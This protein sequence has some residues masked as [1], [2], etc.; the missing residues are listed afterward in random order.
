LISAKS[1]SEHDGWMDEHT[2]T[3]AGHY[4]VIFELMMKFYNTPQIDQ[5][6]IIQKGHIFF[7]KRV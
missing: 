3:T 6:P 5:Y 4:G 2:I 1:W 7:P